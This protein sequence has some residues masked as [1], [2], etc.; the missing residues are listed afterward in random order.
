[1]VSLSHALK[2]R[3]IESEPVIKQN[4][5]RRRKNLVFSTGSFIDKP[6]NENF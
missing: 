5:I 1:M 4:L 6:N 2:S 3:A